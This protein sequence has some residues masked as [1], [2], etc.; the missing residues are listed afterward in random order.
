LV[1]AAGIQFIAALA[2]AMT[3]LLWALT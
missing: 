3:W 1:I 2:M